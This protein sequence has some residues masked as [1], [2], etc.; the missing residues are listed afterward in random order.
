MFGHHG[1]MVIR[2]VASLVL[3]LIG[4]AA[5]GVAA[6]AESARLVNIATRVAVGGVA[7]TPIPGFVVAGTGE[8]AVV[9]RAVGPTLVGFG[10]AGVLADPRLSLV[11]GGATLFSNDNWIAADAAAMAT[12]GAF[13]LTGGSRDAAVVAALGPGSYTAPVTAADGGSG[14]A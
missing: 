10:V 14:V 9:V 2:L 13:S 5:F 3:G 7:G 11:G 1:G 6:E 12:A 8:K 4:L